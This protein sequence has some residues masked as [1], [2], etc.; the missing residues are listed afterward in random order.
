MPSHTRDDRAYVKRRIDLAAAHRLRRPAFS[1]VRRVSRLSIIFLFS[2]RAS[3]HSAYFSLLLYRE[4]VR[5]LLLSIAISS[6]DAAHRD[7]I[8]AGRIFECID[9]FQRWKKNAEKK[10]SKPLREDRVYSFYFSFPYLFAAYVRGYVRE[11]WKEAREGRERERRKARIVEGE[12]AADELIF[13]YANGIG[14]SS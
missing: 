2:F 10:V 4:M 6:I 14:G 11:S 5:S 9:E 13:I 1:T 7:V 12:G 3:F 8:T